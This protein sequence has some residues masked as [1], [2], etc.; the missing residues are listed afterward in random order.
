MTVSREA[1]I[2]FGILGMV[3]AV[4]LWVN[5]LNQ[6]AAATGSVSAQAPLRSSVTQVSEVASQ[7]AAETA[8][9]ESAIIAVAPSPVSD[10]PLVAREVSL[11][12]LPFLVT[13]PPELLA[14]A[15]EGEEATA[16][17]VRPGSRQRASVNPFS[18][19]IV[20]QPAA[21]NVAVAQPQ[22]APAVQVVDVP[23]APPTPAQVTVPVPTASAPTQLANAPRP[24]PLA[25]PSPQA[26]NLPRPLPGGTLPTTPDILREART[27]NTAP[28]PVNLAEVAAVRVPGAPELKFD[29][30]SLDS[31]RLTDEPSAPEP[32]SAARSAQLA[33]RDASSPLFAGAN[34]LSRYLRDNN[35]TFTGAAIGPVA[36]GVFRSS[37]S[38]TP[39]VVSL[40]QSLPDT[41]IVLTDINGQ[42]AEF[43]LDS[44]RQ[45]LILD[46]RR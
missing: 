23:A 33:S 42:Q 10:A 16:G 40:G 11:A 7:P 45:T 29:D 18:P 2:I 9:S 25:P 26:R 32:I 38:S 24:S 14:Q 34:E 17:A 39:I 4:F 27:S 44:H 31:G 22:P 6:P 37:H 21:S 43:T 3:A 19:I 28:Q 41:G 13:A 8:A 12:E 46:L 35:I 1:R 20:R 36:V 30:A 5:I 15:E